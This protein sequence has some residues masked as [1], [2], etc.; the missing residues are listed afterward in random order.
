MEPI[1]LPPAEAM[2]GFDAQVLAGLRARPFFR[3][4]TDEE[5]RASFDAYGSGDFARLI[6]VWQIVAAPTRATLPGI[7]GRSY[8]HAGLAPRAASRAAFLASVR[9]VLAA[10]QRFRARLPPEVAGALAFPWLEHRHEHIPPGW[11]PPLE[12]PVE[13]DAFLVGGTLDDARARWQLLAALN[14]VQQAHYSAYAARLFRLPELAAHAARERALALNYFAHWAPPCSEAL[15]RQCLIVL[16]GMNAAVFEML[17]RARPARMIA[18]SLWE[19]IA[20]RD[21]WRAFVDGLE[22]P[23]RLLAPA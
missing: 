15:W 1:G 8:R 12:F 13:T 20:A 4:V 2:P 5:V 6:D 11:T 16:D 19:A 18:R 17:C 14:E 9:A 10:G 23:Q 3:A 22:R 7:A 21:E